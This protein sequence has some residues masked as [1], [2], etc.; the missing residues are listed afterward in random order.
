[1]LDAAFG[2]FAKEGM[3]GVTISEITD[4]ADV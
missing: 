4:A 3:D 2:V 1:L